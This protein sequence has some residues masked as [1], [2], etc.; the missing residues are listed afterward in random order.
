MVQVLCLLASPGL[1]SFLPL[2]A[3]G[4]LAPP[5]PLAGATIGTIRCASAFWPRLWLVASFGR[6][7]T[8]QVLCLWPFGWGLSGR[9]V[10]GSLAF[11]L[12][13]F[14]PFGWVLSFL[15][16]HLHL[17]AR[18]VEPYTVS[19]R[20][21]CEKCSW[22]AAICYFGLRGKPRLAQGGYGR[23]REAW[24]VGG[25]GRPG[26]PGEAWGSLGKPGEA[27]GKPRKNAVKLGRPREAWGKPRK[28]AVKLGEACGGWLKTCK[29]TIN[30]DMGP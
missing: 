1:A 9:S 26:E 27:W 6:P 20:C 16:R 10:G 13:A 18:K 21:K 2:A 5:G 3:A 11:G 22:F 29:N 14:W 15:Q 8:V 25:L 7:G 23:L 24:G 28:N 19:E 17:H 4:A 30:H 12:G